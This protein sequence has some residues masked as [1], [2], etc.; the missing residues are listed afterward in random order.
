[1]LNRVKS[2]RHLAV[3]LSLL[4]APVLV[5]LGILGGG[6]HEERFEAKQIVVTPIGDDGVRIT[7]VVDDDFG[8]EER[9]GYERFIPNDFGVP[10]DVIASTPFAEDD[11]SVVDLGSETRIRIGDADITHTGQHRYMLSYTLPN[12]RLST[13]TLALDIIGN[14]ET[15]ETGR[16]EIVL[17]GFEL[18]NPLCNVGASGTSGGCEFAKATSTAWSSNPSRPA[19]A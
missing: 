10:Q 11:L 2:W 3:G 13:G 15:L 16:F 6:K 8:D 5:M 4:V 19:T 17:S 9:H 7:E 1:M 12:A 14:D 18:T